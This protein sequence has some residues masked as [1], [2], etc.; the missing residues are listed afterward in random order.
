VQYA[1]LNDVDLAGFKS[2][3]FSVA[4]FPKKTFYDYDRTTKVS[5]NH[6]SLEERIGTLTSPPKVILSRLPAADATPKDPNAK[7]R[8][9]SSV[10]EF[11]RSRAILSI[12]DDG[13]PDGWVKL[14]RPSIV[15]FRP[16]EGGIIA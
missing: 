13:L 1:A 7:G 9:K 2:T 3:W 14:L 5:V 8:A 15:N 6:R 4:D 11:A 12:T 10:E 16:P